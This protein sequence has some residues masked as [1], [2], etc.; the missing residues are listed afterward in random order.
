M[1]GQYALA[2]AARLHARVTRAVVIAGAVPLDDES[3]FAQLNAMDRRLTKLSVHH[4]HV[5]RSVFKA[6][7]EL[8][9]HQ[10]DVWAHLTARG[11]VPD[12]ATV[13]ESLP[14][15]G[16]AVAAAGALTHTEGM[17][18][19]YRAWVRPWGFTPDD[20]QVPTVIWQGD[21]DELVPP[22]WGHELAARIPDSRL[23]VA[24]GEG[25]FL[26]YRH[27]PEILGDLI[28]PAVTS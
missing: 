16:I 10:P 9:T 22:E 27:Q 4:P 23:V 13:I 8:A 26:G 5:A 28:G 1:G 2:C 19:E 18:E 25:H 6:L 11:A 14:D 7:G 3:A 17:V 20:V 24:E 12:E 15:H 21:A